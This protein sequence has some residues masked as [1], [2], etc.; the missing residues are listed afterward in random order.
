[1][2]LC[3]WKIYNIVLVIVLLPNGN[4]PKRLAFEQ[5]KDMKIPFMPHYSA[6]E[7][8]SSNNNMVLYCILSH[9]HF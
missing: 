7:K 9:F 2:A 1:M 8:L 5:T 3:G 4:K 6:V